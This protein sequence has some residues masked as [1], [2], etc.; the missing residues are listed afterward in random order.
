MVVCKESLLY[1]LQ[2]RPTLLAKLITCRLD[3]CSC[4]LLGFFLPISS[5]SWLSSSSV[6]PTPIPSHFLCLRLPY[7]SVLLFPTIHCINSLPVLRVWH[8]LQVCSNV[9]WIKLVLW[10]CMCDFSLLPRSF[11]HQRCCSQYLLHWKESPGF[12]P[13]NHILCSFRTSKYSLRSGLSNA[14]LLISSI[15]SIGNILLDIKCINSLCV[16]YTPKIPL[17]CDI[18]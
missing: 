8:D 17:K 15:T 2:N 6:L 1:G 16:S 7:Y 4:P 10:W 5:T 11:Q 9:S 3:Y 14:C 13:W 12:S 18:S